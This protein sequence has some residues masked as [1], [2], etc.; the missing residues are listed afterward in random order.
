VTDAMRPGVV[1]LPHGWGH[2]RPG[3]RLS[4]AATVP[5]A[6]S[7]ALGDSNTVDALSGTAAANGIPVAVTPAR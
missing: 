6:N 5:G 3:T 2:D 1:S 7:N 4:I